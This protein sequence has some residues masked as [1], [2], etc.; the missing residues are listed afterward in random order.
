[1]GDILHDKP[2]LE[3]KKSNFSHSEK[4]RG[5]FRRSDGRTIRRV[6][7]YTLQI[8]MKPAIVCLTL[9]QR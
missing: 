7:L 2:S 5:K 3:N 6:R 8:V 4:A 9:V 1:M